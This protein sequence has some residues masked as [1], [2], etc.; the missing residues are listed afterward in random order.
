MKY[1]TSLINVLYVVVNNGIE[2]NRRLASEIDGKRTGHERR[3]SASS[4][5][6]VREQRIKRKQNKGKQ[7]RKGKKQTRNKG[8]K[9]K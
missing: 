4:I 9:K 5:S 2:K 6:P 8:S 1:T 7:G 3:K